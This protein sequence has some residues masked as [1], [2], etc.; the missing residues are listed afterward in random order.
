MKLQ[1]LA[2][3]H[4]ETKSVITNTEVDCTFPTG[5]YPPPHSTATIQLW[6]W[7]SETN[8][9]ITTCVA[10]LLFCQMQPISTFNFEWKIGQGTEENGERIWVVTSWFSSN[11]CKSHDLCML[12]GAHGASALVPPSLQGSGGLRWVVENKLFAETHELSTQVAC[13][14][15]P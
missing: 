13:W 11:C 5:I 1:Y 6:Q 15:S 8:I 2:V 3:G 9:Q 12:M 10:C 7:W 4:L 14:N